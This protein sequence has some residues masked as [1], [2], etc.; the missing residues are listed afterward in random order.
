[1]HETRPIV[2][3]LLTWPS[4]GEQTCDR[5]DVSFAIC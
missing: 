4:L 2:S 1:V 5:N 3:L